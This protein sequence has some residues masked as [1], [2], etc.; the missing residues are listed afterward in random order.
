MN[1][2]YLLIIVIITIIVS[3]ILIYKNKEN[4]WKLPKKEPIKCVKVF[5]HNDKNIPLPSDYVLSV[6]DEIKF[7]I[8]NNSLCDKEHL[9]NL[10]IHIIQN[11]GELPT[12]LSYIKY[13]E[14]ING[15]CKLL[16]VNNT[17][18]LKNLFIE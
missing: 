15:N 1:N 13:G 7:M 3:I 9:V 4:Y 10:L 17:I 18:I 6:N 5:Y 2:I 14:I 8:N 12:L 11:Q 16:Y